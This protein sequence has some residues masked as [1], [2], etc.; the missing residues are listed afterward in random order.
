MQNKQRF[1]II[2]FFIN[3][4][5]FPESEVPTTFSISKCFFRKVVKCIF[6]LLP[7][8]GFGGWGPSPPDVF[9]IGQNWPIIKYFSLHSSK[10]TPSNT[11]SYIHVM[12]DRAWK[13][14]KKIPGSSGATSPRSA[15]QPLTNIPGCTGPSLRPAKPGQTNSLWSCWF[16][17]QNAA[18]SASASEFTPSW[19]IAAGRGAVLRVWASAS[20]GRN[21]TLLHSPGI[22]H[23]LKDGV[24]AHQIKKGRL[25]PC[26]HY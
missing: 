3:I 14:R 5:T 1:A 9:I 22:L 17:P 18:V 21:I 8:S 26:I 20:Y 16:A 4:N 7:L 25:S 6:M 12:P 23:A 24:F 19:C 11:D 10:K 2:S 13:G 15:A